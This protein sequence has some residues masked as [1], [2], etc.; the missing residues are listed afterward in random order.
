MKFGV[1]LG[2]GER[3]GLAHPDY[4]AEAVV[5]A[6]ELGYESVWAGEHVVMPDYRSRYPYSPDG[7]L[8]QSA[9]TDV[10]D[11]IVWLSYVAGITTRIRLATGVVV[12]PL[13]NPVVLAK[14]VAS[15]DLLSRGRAV[16][17]IG[18]GWMREESDA[19]G[20][21]FDA[22]GQRMEEFVG[23]LRALWRDDVAT[24]HG[25]HVSFAGARSYPKPVQDRTVPIVVGGSG[26]VAAKRA[27]RLGDGYYPIAGTVEDL[28]ELIGV[29]RRAAREA[30][31]DPADVEIS[32]MSFALVGD[33]P[34]TSG[35][36][37]TFRRMEDL[38]VGRIVVPRLLDADLRQA[39]DSL[40]RLADQLLG[41]YV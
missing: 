23:A 18:A 31:R 5:R 24:F 38:G 2:L 19:V 39:L 27:G 35:L 37:D 3:G 32:T 10:P 6:E 16:L 25:E 12:L 7:R 36:L 30:G 41:A 8:P 26:I 34:V 20:V 28:S 1:M 15:L 17:G 33:D 21:P 22:R 29:M 14:Q 13:R 40:E 11:P 4:A 9:Q